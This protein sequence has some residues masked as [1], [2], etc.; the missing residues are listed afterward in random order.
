MDEV[1]AKWLLV[2]VLFGWGWLAMFAWGVLGL[3]R[4]VRKM[5]REGD[6][7]GDE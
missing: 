2:V 6:D 4:H 5:D 1:T 7:D 3:V